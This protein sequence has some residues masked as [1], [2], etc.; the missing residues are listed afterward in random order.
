M[1]I[2]ASALGAIACGDASSSESTTSSGLGPSGGT[3]RLTLSG[4]GPKI[5][6]DPAVQVNEPDAII[7]GLIYD[8]LVT[9]K[10]DWELV[11]QLAERW[12]SDNDLRSWTFEL[13]DG[14]EFH[15]GRPVTSKDVAYSISRLLEEDLGSAVYARLAPEL[16]ASGIK[17]I[18][19]RTVQFN[20]KQ[21]DAFFPVAIGARHCKIIP[22]GTTDFAKPV[23]SGP[24]RFV[25]VDQSKLSFS[26][27]R[28]PNYWK[29]DLPRLDGIE[30]LLSNDQ[31]SL[32]QS[33]SSGTFDFG[34]FIEPSAAASVTQGGSAQLLAHESALFNDLVLAANT[35]PWQNQDVRNAVKLAI[36]REQIL[37]LAYKGKGSVTYDVPVRADDPFFNASLADRTRDVEQAKSL[38]ADAGYPNGI[39]LDLITAPAGSGMVDLAVVAKE[40]LAE[41]GINAK[42]E[43]APADT[44]YDVVWLKESFYVDTWVLRHPL[45]AMAVMFESKA[46]WNESKYHSPEFDQ[47][48]ADARRSG[49][50]DAQKE[51]L[52]EAQALIADQAGFCCPAWL[53]ELYVAKAALT[54]VE[55][56]ATDLVSFERAA[57]S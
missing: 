14:V 44:Y 19:E 48:L 31:T 57:L 27:E 51:T 43:Q 4:G 8:N 16:D 38:L 52:G 47:L 22:D 3:A 49:D 7:D 21:P 26:V 12:E 10:D 23:G 9:V 33:V 24:F 35:D 13:R 25:S 6:L 56:N 42:I 39:N 34:G 1:A 5:V 30:G 45:D 18:D 2:G 40:S 15:N 11:P 41:A 53:D 37:D 55:F 36:D 17:P 46:P 32:V 20:L 50:V 28:N 54:G 29:Q